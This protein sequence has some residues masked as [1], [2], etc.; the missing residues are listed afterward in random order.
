MQF[1]GVLL[2]C[3]LGV[4]DAWSG[5]QRVVEC[6]IQND[7]VVRMRLDG[8]V[9]EKD[10]QGTFS[11][12]DVGVFSHHKSLARK[13]PDACQ[14]MRLNKDSLVKKR[15][16]GFNYEGGL[17]SVMMVNARFEYDV[18]CAL[19]VRLMHKW[20]VP[21]NSVVCATHY[22]ARG[23][24]GAVDVMSGR[25]VRAK[26][27][28]GQDPCNDFECYWSEL[29]KG[30]AKNA[31]FF[32]C[33]EED[34]VHAGEFF[35]RWLLNATQ[36]FQRVLFGFN[37]CAN[38]NLSQREKDIFGEVFDENV[39][40][41]KIVIAAVRAERLDSGKPYDISFIKSKAFVT[42]CE[43]WKGSLRHH[44]V[45]IVCGCFFKDVTR[46]LLPDNPGNTLFLYKPDLSHLPAPEG[47]KRVDVL[48]NLP[49]AS[50]KKYECDGLEEL[51][52]CNSLIVQ[53][54]IDRG[55][56]V[57]CF[58]GLREDCFADDLL[59]YPLRQ[60][61][62]GK[63]TSFAF[64]SALQGEYSSVVGVPCES[65]KIYKECVLSGMTCFY[66]QDTVGSVFE[67]SMSDAG[68]GFFL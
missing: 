3:C 17:E 36:S 5:T 35:F 61:D 50:N 56:L 26:F 18:S 21:E 6:C 20:R 32:G 15:G 64:S 51:R 47:Q 9:F 53:A 28:N 7:C 46:V 59:V 63:L 66:D 52:V 60:K 2:V 41:P 42:D 38:L 31:I 33:S 22:G 10:E 4:F 54:L 19:G 49:A 39:L 25:L 44:T 8:H 29:R 68:V 30:N 16:K 12:T 40:F 67:V 65:R 13:S 43:R 1:S 45:A 58:Y 27:S 24:V 55:H 14:A 37:F 62:K 57:R 48:M 11:C 23:V 34:I